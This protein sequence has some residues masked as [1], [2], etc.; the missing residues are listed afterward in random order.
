M[1]RWSL[2]LILILLLSGCRPEAKPVD[3]DRLNPEH[4][5]R[6][7]Q[8]MRERADRWEGVELSLTGLFARSQ[9]ICFLVRTGSEGKAVGL[10]LQWTG[11]DPQPGDRVTAHGYLK[12][13]EADG[14]RYLALEAFQLVNHSALARAEAWSI[15]EAFLPRLS[16]LYD[17][18]A[19]HAGKRITI[20]GILHLRQDS[21]SIERTAHY[22]LGDSGPVGLRLRYGGSLPEEGVWVTATGLLITE[23]DLPVLDVAELIP[24]LPGE[25][26]VWEQTPEVFATENDP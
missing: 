17:D 25:T 18:P 14:A 5:A 16:A 7:L 20:S 26:E 4:F 12:T 3:L 23:Q 24:G 21:P 8:Q 13:Y 6:T 10:E 2:V 19:A 9:G 15:D 11:T 22:A 1:R